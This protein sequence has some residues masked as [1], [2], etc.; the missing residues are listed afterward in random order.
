MTL[1]M[2]AAIDS[3]VATSVV[4]RTQ[5]VYHASVTRPTDENQL[6]LQLIIVDKY[7]YDEHSTRLM[8]HLRKTVLNKFYK[9]EIFFF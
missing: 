5:I 6:Y 9:S 4:D 7:D 2:R 8:E 1:M 3:A